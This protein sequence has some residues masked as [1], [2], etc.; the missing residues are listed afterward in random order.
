LTV[1]AVYARRRAMQ[2]IELLSCAVECEGLLS[3]L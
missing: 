3:C 2:A 1:Y